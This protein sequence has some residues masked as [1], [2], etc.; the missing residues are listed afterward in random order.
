[1]TLRHAEDEW[2]ADLSL[3]LCT[4]TRRFRSVICMRSLFQTTPAVQELL[5][6]FLHYH[7]SLGFDHVYV[8]DF[9][10]TANSSELRALED[11][12]RLTYHVGLEASL[13]PRVRAIRAEEMPYIGW[14]RCQIAELNHCLF[15]AK[16]EAEWIF[17]IRGFD[18]SLLRESCETRMQAK[19][20]VDGESTSVN[21]ILSS[22]KHNFRIS[23]TPPEQLKRV[24]FSKKV[25]RYCYEE[26]L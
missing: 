26:N 13:S 17:A 16:A 12:G 2:N 10:G 5:Q 3:E 24:R 6:T 19:P 11:A 22:E 9:D 4:S 18:K 21:S 14:P 23:K 25:E 20:T 7:Y 1:M 8:Y 15:R